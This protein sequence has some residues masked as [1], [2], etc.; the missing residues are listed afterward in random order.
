M[1]DS[2]VSKMQTLNKPDYCPLLLSLTSSSENL[3]M[4]SSTVSVLAIVPWKP[5]ATPIA[6]CSGAS[7][8]FL[9]SPTDS[10]VPSRSL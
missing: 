10:L 6:Y 1:V 3:E 8:F 9:P 5:F 7:H 4:V 2:Q